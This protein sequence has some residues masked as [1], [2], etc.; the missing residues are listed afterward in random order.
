MGCH[1]NE[2]DYARSGRAHMQDVLCGACASGGVAFQLWRDAGMAACRTHR[3]QWGRADWVG[4]RDADSW[5]VSPAESPTGLDGRRI[6]KLIFIGLVLAQGN[7]YLSYQA[8]IAVVVDLAMV[9]LKN[10]TGQ[11]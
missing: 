1:Q 2:V 10:D 4:G 6:S 11:W 5:R 7:R 9:A 3:A 8:G